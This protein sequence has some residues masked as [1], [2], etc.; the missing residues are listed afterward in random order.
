VARD[1]GGV[2]GAGVGLMV[3]LLIRTLSCGLVKGCFKFIETQPAAASRRDYRFGP[4]LAA[5]SAYF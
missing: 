5:A 4:A 2:G 1:P 3:L